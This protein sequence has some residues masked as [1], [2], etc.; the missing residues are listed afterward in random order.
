MDGGPLEEGCLTIVPRSLQVSPSYHAASHYW[1]MDMHY[2]ICLNVQVD[3]HPWLTQ[4]ILGSSTA[5]RAWMISAS[6]ENGHLPNLTW[7]SSKASLTLVGNAI[8]LLLHVPND[9]SALPDS[10]DRHTRAV[11]SFSQGWNSFI[12]LFFMCLLLIVLLIAAFQAIP[13]LRLSIGCLQVHILSGSD[14]GGR[15]RETEML[16]QGS[17]G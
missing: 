5:D 8:I 9:A 6:A 4:K 11:W 12:A 15:E 3:V 16:R 1:V 10:G 2:I 7:N 13:V 14:C 17:E